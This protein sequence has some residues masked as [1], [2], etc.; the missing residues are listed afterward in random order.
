MNILRNC[1]YVCEY[2]NE[3]AFD[4]WHCTCLEFLLGKLM[5]NL[6]RLTF[7]FRAKYDA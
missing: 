3:V 4:E 2:L 5:P 6:A 1:I 7:V